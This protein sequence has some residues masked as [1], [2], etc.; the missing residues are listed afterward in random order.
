M[1]DRPETATRDRSNWEDNLRENLLLLATIVA[2][3]T[4]AAGFNPPGGV[5][6]DTDATAGHLA[7][8]PIIRDTI[9]HRFLVFY[10]SNATAF[11]SSIW[12]VVLILTLP[13][14]QRWKTIRKA[15]LYILRLV[16]VVDLL[17][18]IVAYG[19]GTGQYKVTVI[20]FIVFVLF[21]IVNFLLGHF[22]IVKE[23]NEIIKKEKEDNQEKQ[24]RE[25]LMTLATFVVSVAYLA[26]LNAPGGFWNQ[27]ESGH[28]PGEE[29][30]KGRHDTRL[31]LFVVFNTSAFIGSLVIIVQLL[32]KK[33]S[34]NNKVLCLQLYASVAL[35]LCGLIGA[36]IAGSSREN[37]TAGYMIALLVGLSTC[38]II[39]ILIVKN[40]GDSLKK[41][42]LLETLRRIYVSMTELFVRKEETSNFSGSFLH[43]SFSDE[44][45]HI[46]KARALVELLATL[47]AIITYQAGLDPPGGLWEEDG[48]GHKAGDPILLTRSPRRYKAFFYCNSVAF[49]ASLLAIILLR[50]RVMLKYHALESAMI[51]DLF[52]L[53]GAYA[54]GSSRDVTT[55][56]YA[57]AMAGAVLV[58]VVI[59]V[60]FFTLDHE[61]I[62]GSGEATS[63]KAIIGDRLEKRRQLL[64]LLAIMAATLTYQAGL[65]PP[66]GF[67]L[68]DDESG[69]RAGD[70]VLFYNYPRRYKAF[71]YCNS[72]SFM[73]SIA[74]I[75][76]LV[77]KNLYIPAIRSNALSVCTAVGMFSLVGAYA[78]GSTQH[79]KTSIYIFVLAAVVLLLVVLLVVVFSVLHM[80]RKT[81]SEPQGQIQGGDVVSQDTNG[82]LQSQEKVMAVELNVYGD[83]SSSGN[84]EVRRVE[85]VEIGREAPSAPV[86]AETKDTDDTES[87]YAKQKYVMMLGILVASVTYQAGLKPPGGM[88]QDDGAEHAA[89]NPIMYDN[90]RLRYQVFFYVNTTSF[91]ASIIVTILMLLESL[92]EK[93]WWKL[94]VL[95]TTIALDLFG[96]LVAYAVGSARSWKTTG[97]V[98]ALVVPVLIYV[99]SHVTLSRFIHSDKNK[100]GGVQPTISS[101]KNKVDSGQSENGGVV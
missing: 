63:S 41:C 80:S 84:A 85:T 73:L 20:F 38:I 42:C 32:D 98:L 82:V 25:V 10:Y 45:K 26:G 101:D 100:A 91:V 74:L 65:T 33:L 59:H 14:V 53:I 92:E 16:M 36:Y 3:V 70:P 78:A 44:E 15:G 55:S 52:G 93:E 97:K 95:N 47:A 64:L 35:S 56:I 79:L 62:I 31:I 48:D 29:V 7:G 37:N 21:G 8:D 46:W 68:R 67:R 1:E 83:T 34:T 51:L 4:Y 71:F 19:F 81:S 94:N 77:N 28:R 90:M 13:I 96:L 60:V 50:K 18:L 22:V 58:Y 86:I 43:D 54:A 9:Y 76:L 69:H 87:L 89:G 5:W 72:V 24:R 23:E 11:A 49:V 66:S 88:W 40:Y 6:Q 57:I 27:E 17:S 99:V 12:T 61:D 2:A 30:L 39:Q 75:I